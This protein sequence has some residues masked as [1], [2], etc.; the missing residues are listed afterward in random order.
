[1]ES[2]M[3]ARFPFHLLAKP[4]GPV[5]NLDCT[6][7][8]YLEKEKLYGRKESW[9]MDDATL[10]RYVRDY[11]AA[12]PGE[13]A[14]F[15]FQGGEPT[16]LGVP[17]F[18]KVVA[19]QRK[20]AAGKRIENSIQT[21]G[22]L[23]DDTWG[24]F[25][26][27]NRFLVGLSL[28]GPRDLHDPWRV[29]RRQQPTFDKVMAGADLLKRHGVEFNLLACVNATT[30]REPERVYDFLK[31][32]G[33]PFL[34]FIPIVEREVDPV[35]AKLGL[36]LGGPPDLRNPPNSREAPRM[37]PWSVDPDAYGEFLVRIFERWIA[38]DV[39][40]IFVQII[41][42]AAARWLG[43]PAGICVFEETCGRALA[44]EHN[45]DV[46]TCDHFVYPDQKIGNL[47]TTP[48][49]EIAESPMAL[50]FGNAKRDTLPRYCRECDVRFACNGE[51]PKHRFTWTPDGEWGLNYLCQAY[52]R[53]FHHIAPAMERIA[54]LVRNR[55]PLDSL[56]EWWRN[57]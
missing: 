17:Y 39:G 37:T 27:E 18:E 32:V 38:E 12:Q 6:Y 22:T 14:S 20:H 30:V 51:C 56:G 45:G 26:A 5:C 44:L 46:Y 43:L 54:W 15:A 29:D 34:Q 16:L 53:F 50:A 9:R 8:F 3:P 41:E 25:L 48:L 24:A 23:L 35:A 52:K 13:E 1:M 57:A 21:N 40:E 11:I 49:A 2:G 33:T 55:Q 4:I 36:D 28:D 47:N 42:S 19:L 7:C 31:S 10:D